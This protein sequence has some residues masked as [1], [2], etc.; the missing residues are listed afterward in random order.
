MIDDLLARVKREK[1]TSV[2]VRLCFVERK[3]LSAPSVKMES[4][5]KAVVCGRMVKS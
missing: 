3:F 5:D 2:V 4:G 1:D